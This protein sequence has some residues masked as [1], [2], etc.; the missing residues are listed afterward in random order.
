MEK[1]VE[2]G[3][4]VINC[5]TKEGVGTFVINLLISLNSRIAFSHSI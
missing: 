5:P 2:S 4:V 1:S 3:L